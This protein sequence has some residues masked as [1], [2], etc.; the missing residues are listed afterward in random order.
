MAK[1]L[2]SNI[3]GL[4]PLPLSLVTVASS[5]NIPDVFT[6]SWLGVLCTDPLYIG[7]GI[8]AAHYAH[9]LIE[10]NGEFTVNIMEESFVRDIDLLGRLSGQDVDKFEQA[11]ITAS[12]AKEVKA[13]TILEAAISIECKVQDVVRLGAEDLYIGRVVAT[14]VE[15]LVLKDEKLDIE[16]LR[17]V[18]YAADAYWSIGRRIGQVGETSRLRAG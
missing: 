15:E 6:S 3:I 11:R 13:P 12:P 5:D 8:N 17:P 14:H 9:S 10:D 16:A 2:V 7:V 4:L 18:A 1:K